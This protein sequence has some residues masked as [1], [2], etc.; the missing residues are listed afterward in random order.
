MKFKNLSIIGGGPNAVYALD[1]LLKNILK[2]KITSKKNIYIFESTGLFG[3]G[4]THSI[5]LDKNIY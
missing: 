1:I 3:C 5:N 4:K 2:K